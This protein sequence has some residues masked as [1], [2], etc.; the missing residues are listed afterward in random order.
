MRHYTLFPD[1]F[2]RMLTR[3]RKVN[4]PLFRKYGIIV[5]RVWSHPTDPNKFSFLMSFPNEEARKKAWDGYH[6]DPDFIAGKETQATIIESIEWH[7]LEPL[8][9][10]E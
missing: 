10:S 6:A 3:F 4:L 2:D 5:E 8:L 9:V 1:S 7:V